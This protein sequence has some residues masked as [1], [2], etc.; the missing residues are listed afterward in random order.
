MAKRR[1]CKDKHLHDGHEWGHQTDSQATIKSGIFLVVERGGSRSRRVPQTY[2]C[3]GRS[4][5]EGEKQ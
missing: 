3:P 4:E 1:R 5:P 2:W